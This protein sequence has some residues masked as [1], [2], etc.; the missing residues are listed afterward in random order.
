MTTR[1][2]LDCGRLT[3]LG[4]RCRDCKRVVGRDRDRAKRARRPYVDAERMRRAQ[5]VEAWRAEHGDWCPG[6]QRPPHPAT[7]LT[8][9]H[10]VAFAVV[11]HENSQLAV[12]CRSCNGAKGKR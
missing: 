9:D 6:W 11:G 12:L 8:A 7:D 5:V 4:A 1:P 3:K 2:C 10:V